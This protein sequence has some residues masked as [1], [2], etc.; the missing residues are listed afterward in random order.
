MRSAGG[1]GTPRNESLAMSL[2][3]LHSRR[4]VLTWPA[5]GA[6]MLVMV[7]WQAPSLWARGLSWNAVLEFGFFVASGGLMLGLVGLWVVRGIRALFGGNKPRDG[8]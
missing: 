4:A 1:C 8:S 5:L 3:D 7:L 2:P 6:G